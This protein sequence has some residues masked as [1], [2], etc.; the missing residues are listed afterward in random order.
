MFTA[1][2]LT[3]PLRPVT[4]VA[5]SHFT[6][7]SGRRACPRV[8]VLCSLHILHSFNHNL[9]DRRNNLTLICVIGRECHQHKLR[10]I[11]QLKIRSV[12]ARSAGPAGLRPQPRSRNSLKRNSGEAVT[13]IVCVLAAPGI[14]ALPP[15]HTLRYP[16]RA[17]HSLL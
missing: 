5:S 11:R 8:P 7:G 12:V 14:V 4:F 1:D 6:S 17:C 16:P 9:R 3:S 13:L 10:T 15:N 2:S